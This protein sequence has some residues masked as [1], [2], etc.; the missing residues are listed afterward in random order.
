MLSC[1]HGT[2]PVS[3]TTVT[4]RRRE[5]EPVVLALRMSRGLRG[6]VNA[7]LVPARKMKIARRIVFRGMLCSFSIASEITCM[8]LLHRAIG[9]SG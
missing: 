3:L 6:L 7:G 5:V 1:F 9:S 4:A 8:L 2:L